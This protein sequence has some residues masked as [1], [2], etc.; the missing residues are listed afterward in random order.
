M[1]THDMGQARRIA[2][3]VLFLLHGR[4]HEAARGSDPL[5]RLATPEA[6]AFLKGDIVE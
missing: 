6:Q 2:T 3:E 4:L 1:A 5:D